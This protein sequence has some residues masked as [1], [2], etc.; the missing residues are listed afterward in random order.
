MEVMIFIFLLKISNFLTE[1]VQGN[2]KGPV[3][4]PLLVLF[5]LTYAVLF[6]LHFTKIYLTLLE[7]SY[8]MP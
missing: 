1:V 2:L 8:F 6:F 7:V 5:L 4:E 3:L